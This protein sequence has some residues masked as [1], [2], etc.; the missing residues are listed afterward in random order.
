[1]GER[2]S[3]EDQ[4]KNQKIQFAGLVNDDLLKVMHDR[5]VSFW[6]ADT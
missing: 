3:H 6:E 1:M 4:Y 5:L 2:K